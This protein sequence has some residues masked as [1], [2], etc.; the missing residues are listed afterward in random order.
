MPAPTLPIIQQRPATLM[1]IFCENEVFQLPLGEDLLGRRLYCLLTFPYG[2][3][4]RYAPSPM[5]RTPHLLEVKV[6]AAALSE[7][8]MPSSPNEQPSQSVLQTFDIAP[9]TQS[10][11]PNSVVIT[12]F[13]Y[14]GVS[15]YKTGLRFDPHRAHEM[16]Y[17][18]FSDDCKRDLTIH[19]FE[20]GPRGEITL[21]MSH[22]ILDLEGIPWQ[23][24]TT[25]PNAAGQQIKRLTTEFQSEWA[26]EDGTLAKA[27]ILT[28]GFEFGEG[29][30]WAVEILLRGP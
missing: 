24:E 18:T 19:I 8:F 3:P 27:R 25:K 30:I 11:Y 4:Q 9:V 17:R 26:L 12:T 22:D 21:H 1:W 7:L 28:R 10:L 15:D 13:S 16:D 20:S 29:Y 23:R 5:A 2:P 6:P 14:H